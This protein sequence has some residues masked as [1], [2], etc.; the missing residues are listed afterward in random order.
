MLDRRAIGAVDDGD[1]IADDGPLDFR[2]RAAASVPLKIAERRAAAAQ[3][4][5]ALPFRDDAR[6]HPLRVAE[7]RELRGKEVVEA[8]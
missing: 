2:E 1:P 6:R 7:P 3:V 8:E 5:A 4:K